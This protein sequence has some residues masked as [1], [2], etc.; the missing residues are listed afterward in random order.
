MT[1]IT[2]MPDLPRAARRPQI[3]NPVLRWLRANLFSSIPNGIL[4]VV[5]LAVLAKGV[6][7]V[8]FVLADGEPFWG[9]DRFPQLER[10]LA[11]SRRAA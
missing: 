1:A 9:Y 8:P 4:T 6:F 11:A 7:G 5:L 2:D 3:G 10:W